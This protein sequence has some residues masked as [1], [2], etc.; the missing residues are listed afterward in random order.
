MILS[1]SC[2]W[3]STP[4][5][6]SALELVETQASPFGSSKTDLPTASRKQ[7]TLVL[8]RA[9]KHSRKQWTTGQEAEVVEVEIYM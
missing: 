7:I 2:S 5:A 8:T 1:V 9:G 6:R 4:E 3:C